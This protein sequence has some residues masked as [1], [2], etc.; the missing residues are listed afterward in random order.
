MFQHKSRAVSARVAVRRSLSSRGAF[1]IAFNL[2]SDLAS[3]PCP[4]TSSMCGVSEYCDLSAFPM[5]ITL[6][7]NAS[8]VTYLFH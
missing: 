3:Q 8:A 5:A 1:R 2:G 7:G 6:I 4:V